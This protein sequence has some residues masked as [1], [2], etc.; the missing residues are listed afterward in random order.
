MISPCEDTALGMTLDKIRATVSAVLAI[1]ALTDSQTSAALLSRVSGANLK[2]V[3][4]A[5]LSVGR[6][7]AREIDG[8]K[9]EL[10]DRER[11]REPRKMLSEDQVLDLVPF[12]RTTLFSLI[13]N[14]AFPRATYA[15]ANR[16]FWFADEIADWQAALSEGNPLYN[17]ARRRGGGRRPRNAAASNDRR[18]AP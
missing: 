2:Q 1:A 4:T 16:R 15:S 6:A 5:A 9:C 11:P 13:K 17:A 10:A 7:Q 8:L 3:L 12:A 18:P 14:G